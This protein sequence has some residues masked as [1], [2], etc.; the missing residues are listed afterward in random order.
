MEKYTRPSKAHI[1]ALA[2]TMMAVG[3]GAY[4]VMSSATSVAAQTPE[5]VSDSVD[6]TEKAS[7]GM[8]HRSSELPH[9][10]T[11]RGEGQRGRGEHAR[12]PLAV[13]VATELTAAVKNAVPGGTIGRLEAE[14]HEGAVYEAHVITA[15]GVHMEITF[16]E[17]FNEV[18]REEKHFDKGAFGRFKHN[19][20]D[21]ATTGA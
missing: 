7:Y 6:W 3:G 20:V 17:N 8:R 13:D 10:G 11:Q 4:G 2:L 9:T 14:E 1:T 5:E 12:A 18:S 15:D 16:D 21:E 19:V